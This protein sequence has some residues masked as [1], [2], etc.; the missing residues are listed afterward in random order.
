[1]KQFVLVGCAAALLGGCSTVKDMGSWVGG[2]FEPRVTGSKPAELTEFKPMTSL[3]RAWDVNVGSSGSYRFEPGSDGQA[4]FAAGREGRIVKIDPA[5]GRELARIDTGKPLSAGVGIGS[6]L[7]LV[8]TAK[9]EVLAYRSD[10]LQPAWS[11]SL[12]GEIITVPAAEGGRVAVRSNNGNVALFNAEDGKLRWSYPRTQPVLTLREAGAIAF[13]PGRLFVGHAGGKLSALAVDNGGPL[14]EANVAIPRGATELERIA[15]VVGPLAVDAQGVC[16]VAF[17]GRVA[18]FDQRTGQAV[19]GRDLSSLNGVEMDARN[20]YVV[21]DR[22][23]V[24]AFDK[25]R[26]VNLWKQEVLR[27]RRVS[28]PL[29]QGT[30]LAVGD[31]QGQVHLLNRDDGALAARAGTDGSAIRAPMLPLDRGLV[32]QTV[33][34]GLYAFKIQ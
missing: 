2:W 22:A 6:G 12:G 33:N 10:N 28:T 26:G 31:L 21:D 15:D 19:W 18:C 9:G 13:G 32:V 27:D 30:W 23:T 11:A 20:I 7:V 5:S 17:Q 34:G 1:M 29:A 24:Y 3:V 8:G 16:A 25:T 14:W 4:I